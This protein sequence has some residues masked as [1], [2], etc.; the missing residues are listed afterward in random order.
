MTKINLFGSGYTETSINVNQNLNINNYLRVYEVLGVNNI[1]IYNF[2]YIEKD[3]NLNRSINVVE[4]EQ[5]PIIKIN[6]IDD[7]DKNSFII[8]NDLNCYYYTTFKS[9][10]SINNTLI[11]L[12]DN[13]E[14]NIRIN[15]DINVFNK[16]ISDININK[17]NITKDNSTFTKN[18]TINKDTNLF[19]CDV[20]HINCNNYTTNNLHIINNVNCDSFL[21]IQIKK[22][23][24]I[25]NNINILGNT[26]I[27]QSLIIDGQVD[28]IK[29]S[30]LLLPKKSNN[31]ITDNI[32]LKA[33]SL[34][35]NDER[36]S[37]EYY[38]D[39]WYSISS[40]HSSN[41]KTR[42]KIHENNN[43]TNSNNIEFY[44]NE[45]L[46]VESNNNTYNLN[47]YKKNSNFYKNLNI[48]GI[49]KFYPNNINI[50]NNLVLNKNTF[51][52]KLL[53]LGNKNTDTNIINGFLRFNE[54]LN[55]VQLYNNGWGRL[56]FYSDTNGINIRENNINIFLKEKNNEIKF[57]NNSII[58][59][60]NLNIHS[61]LNNQNF[62]NVANTN[63]DNNIVFNNKASLFF[64][65]NI[66]QAYVAPNYNTTHIDN[67]KI[68]D[69]NAKSLENLEVHYIS[70]IYYVLANFNSYNYVVN[71]Y[72]VND[73]L[74]SNNYKFI[75]LSTSHTNILINKFEIKYFINNSD[76]SNIEAIDLINLKSY[77]HILI[78]LKNK[79]IYNSETNKSEFILEKN[80]YYT[81]QIKLKNN[82]STQNDILLFI[83]LMGEYYS[84]SYYNN[85]IDFIYNIDNSFKNDIEFSNDL[86]IL[87][88]ANFDKSI[89]VK[90]Y[91]HDK[92][93]INNDDFIKNN[94]NLLTLDNHFII[95]NNNIGIGT[96]PDNVNILK[97]KQS[98]F[99]IFNIIGNSLITENI[100]VNNNVNVSNNCNV[101][102]LNYNNLITNNIK[103]I[104]TST[105]NQNIN[106]KNIN[107]E[108]IIFNTN[109]SNLDNLNSKIIT[110]SIMLNNNIYNL[111]DLIIKNINISNNK[112]NIYN[113]FRLNSIGNISINS[114]EIYDAFTIGEKI[115][116]NLSISH[117]GYTI[118]NTTNNGFILDNINVFNKINNLEYIN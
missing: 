33:G 43:L 10:S 40:L 94:S 61:N 114:E 65:D 83:R 101:N 26:H 2:G 4:K 89:K 60:T 20:F 34:R 102:T 69:V 6:N 22:N 23:L 52:N 105:I 66:L 82:F 109:L 59:K 32:I 116:P 113:T 81:I 73:N 5:Y 86:T 28:F 38:L 58:F 104:E 108:N 36:K 46:S 50:N 111:N 56:K 64:K 90:N 112:I 62:I 54:N 41:Y 11:T 39:D 51:I 76:I 72:I 47:I 37:I 93:F 18:I 75:Y 21:N 12:D 3:L 106:C 7:L 103:C 88:N 80:S 85:N 19:N 31:E 35:Y 8:N 71:D 92:I 118:I 117:N 30:M 55:T 97:I 16:V 68:L 98:N 29:N 67:Y 45:I 87:K 27:K 78:Y 1:Q 79:L 115:N 107:C 49:I 24:D 53:I 74:I 110:N 25:S 44:Q 100:N 63:I 95:N 84:D 17:I 99:D 48:D 77:Y 70:N 42:L 9:L 96:I 91:F 14:Q 15:S 13:Y 57:N